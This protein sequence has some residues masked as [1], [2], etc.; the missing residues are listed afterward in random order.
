MGE[1]F[2]GCSEGLFDDI[3]EFSDAMPSEGFHPEFEDVAINFAM[4]SRATVFDNPPVVLTD[5]LNYEEISKFLQENGLL[6]ATVHDDYTFLIAQAS[7]PT[8]QQVIPLI[9]LLSLHS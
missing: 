4:S 2:P 6:A 1:I 8:A 9:E 3:G 7:H 5:E